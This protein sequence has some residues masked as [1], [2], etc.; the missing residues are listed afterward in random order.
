MCI[1]YY[2]FGFQN[3]FE[4]ASPINHVDDKDPPVLL[5]YWQ[6]NEDL[7]KNVSGEIYIHHPK[8]G[9]HLKEKMDELNVECLLKIYENNPNQ[10][11]VEIIDFFK[12]SISLIS[13]KN[14]RFM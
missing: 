2:Q 10:A 14:R 13:Y 6:K 5:H 9:F 4:W 8:F 12:G 1:L 3:L 11:W 7:P